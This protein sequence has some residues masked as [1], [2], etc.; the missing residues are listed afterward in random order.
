V[1]GDL[2]AVV[3]RQWFELIGLTVSTDACLG[4]V[5]AMVAALRAASKNPAV[6]IIVGG[7][8]FSEHPELATRVGA[9]GT[10]PDAAR[11]LLMAERLVD[12]GLARSAGR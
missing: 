8:I 1:L 4:D 6:G 5:P 3:G 12:R 7:A 10:A 9:D 2:C 11:A